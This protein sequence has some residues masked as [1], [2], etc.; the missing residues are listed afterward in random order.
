MLKLNTP[1]VTVNYPAKKFDELPNIDLNL[2]TDFN[3]LTV[4]QWG[5]RKNLTNTV[6]WFLEEFK[7]EEVGLIIK[8]NVSKNCYMDREMVLNN[9]RSLAN[10]VAPDRKCKLH[11]LH[12]DMTDEEMHSIYTHEKVSALVALP[13]GEGFGLP[14]LEAGM[15]KLPIACTEIPP[16]MEV[17]KDVCFFRPSDPPLFIAGRIIEYLSRTTTHRMF[18]KVMKEYVL[19]EVCKNHLLPYL[20]EIT[21]RTAAKV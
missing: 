17:G 12:G 5:P 8:T 11:L 9:L 21:G 13:H 2:D 20:F 4:A 3:F 19:Y 6:K 7:D 18:R 14:L 10:Q 15:I 16:F 1:I